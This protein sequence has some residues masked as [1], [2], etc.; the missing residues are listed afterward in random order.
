MM[1][2]KQQSSASSQE[3]KKMAKKQHRPLK[4]FE[5]EKDDGNLSPL[6]SSSKW[7]EV[8]NSA[9][10]EYGM[11]SNSAAMSRGLNNMSSSS[12]HSRSIEAVGMRPMRHSQNKHK[13]CYYEEISSV[14]R[15]RLAALMITVAEEE[16]SI[17]R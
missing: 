14:V 3:K 6:R 2:H 4:P 17:E 13:K 11:R 10:K 12:H 7:D 15:S 16:L 1:M 8:H 9:I 5:Q